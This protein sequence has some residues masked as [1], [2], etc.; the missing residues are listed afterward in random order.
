MV[1][2]ISWLHWESGSPLVCPLIMS[3]MVWTLTYFTLCSLLPERNSE[4]CCRLVT[5]VHALLVSVICAVLHLYYG[6]APWNALGLDNKPVHNVVLIISLGY[7]LFDFTWCCYMR[8]EGAAMLAHHVVSI[9]GLVYSYY[10]HISGVEVTAVCFGAEITNPMVQF[11]W[12][13][14]KH[15]LYHSQIGMLNDYLFVF[16]FAFWRFGIGTYFFYVAMTHD[17]VDM[18][19]KAGALGL[20]VI[21]AVFMWHIAKFFVRKYVWKMTKKEE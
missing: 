3:I 11:R 4:Y 9:V 6:P 1:F 2:D 5:L 14:K 8:T 12:F 21:S 13:L 7:F 20:Y 18:M 10:F 16:S 15:F 17:K 19:I